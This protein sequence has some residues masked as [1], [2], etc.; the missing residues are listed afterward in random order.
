[1]NERKIDARAAEG[2]IRIEI[3][4]L[5]YALDDVSKD[6]VCKSLAFQ[7]R[8]VECVVKWLVN[9]EVEWD[10]PEWDTPGHDDERQDWYYWA[11]G[12]KTI[13]EEVRLKLLTQKDGLIN[14]IVGDLIKKRDEAAHQC[15]QWMR[16]CWKIKDA[17]RDAK[18]PD[19]R[20]DYCSKTLTEEEVAT[21]LEK[22]KL[23]IATESVAL[24][25]GKAVEK[26]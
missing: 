7:Q 21:W 12:H 8:L 24:A 1:M 19:D 3:E 22:E 5:F 23:R 15:D 14:R 20:I 2:C 13:L 4:D 26:A 18:C 16:L 17:W 10:N 25:E 11:T 6:R 9:G